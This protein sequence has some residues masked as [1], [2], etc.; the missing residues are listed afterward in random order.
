MK[1]KLLGGGREVGR[2]GI[3]LDDGAKR[4]LIDYGLNPGNPP[5]F[6]AA[7]P[8]VDFALLSH[9]HLDHSGM[10]PWLSSRYNTKIYSTPL[11]K[12]ISEVL[13]KDMLKI[14]ESNGYPFPYGEH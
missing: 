10:L 6:P 1:V 14:A 7:S 13:Y 3:L 12:E 5:S 9:A 4:L 8:P 11:T 2:V